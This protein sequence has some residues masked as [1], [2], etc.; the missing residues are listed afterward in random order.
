MKRVPMLIQVNDTESGSTCL[1]MIL[2]YYK[3]FLP[4]ITL[5]EACSVSRDGC[6]IEDIKEGAADY[7]LDG[8]IHQCSIETLSTAQLPCILSMND[9]HFVVLEGLKNNMATYCDPIAGRQKQPIEKLSKTY[10]GYALTLKKNENFQE[11][12]KK[13]DIL[14]YIK[15]HISYSPQGFVKYFIV[16]GLILII[17]LAMPMLQG[18]FSE[19]V[20]ENV[21]KTAYINILTIYICLFLICIVLHILKSQISKDLLVT[22]DIQAS[23]SLINAVFNLPLTFYSA[24]YTGDLVSRIKANSNLSKIIVNYICTLAINISMIVVCLGIMFSYSVVLSSFV[25]VLAAVSIMLTIKVAQKRQ[26]LLQGF[27]NHAC[28]RE[29]YLYRTYDTL[30]TI[31]IFGA[32]RACTQQ[33]AALEAKCSQS[34]SRFIR[35]DNTEGLI[36]EMISNFTS[37]AIFIIG[38]MLVHSGNILAGAVLV[39]HG[40]YSIINDPIVSVTSVGKELFSMR[41]NIQLIHEVTRSKQDKV[42]RTQTELDYKLKGDIVLDNITFGYHKKKPP[43]F[44]D[45]SLSIKQGERVAIVGQSGCGKTTLKSIISGESV[46]WNGTVTYDGYCRDEIS[47]DIFSASVSLVNQN[48]SIFDDTILQNIKLWDESIEDFEAILASNDA[49]LHEVVQSRPKGYETVLRKNGSSLSGGQRQKIEIARALATEPTIIIL[50]EATS[51]LDAISEQKV[52]QKIFMRGATVIVIAHRVSAIRDCDKIVVMEK[53]KILDIGTH[54][55]LIERCEYYHTL[56]SN[57]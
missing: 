55:E 14:C 38:A 57:A 43:F 28:R 29:N 33:Y 7:N 53:G 24:R 8:T 16:L 21:E 41:Y 13:S 54:D 34:E 49:D 3:L 11:Q 27:I 50:D 35:L 18:R 19:L 15:E 51:A 45:F 48:I 30:D 32:D 1:A 5:R 6:S 26:E 40:I 52:M 42:T 17:S 23:K 2:G 25:V 46:V 36:P 47:D 9:Q 37:V 4:L 10:S 39:L 31:K 56:I 12:K 22:V 20:L 44:K